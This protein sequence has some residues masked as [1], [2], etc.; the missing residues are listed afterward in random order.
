MASR[1][2]EWL[3]DSVL[4]HVHYLQI[5]FK[6]LKGMLRRFG[7]QSLQRCYVIWGIKGRGYA[8]NL[9]GGRPATAPSDAFGA[10]SPSSFE[11]L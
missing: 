11:R 3:M 4:C 1:V 8:I 7:S 10:L 5:T 2:N 9:T 6:E